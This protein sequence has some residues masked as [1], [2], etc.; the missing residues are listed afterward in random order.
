[1]KQES[2]RKKISEIYN[3]YQDEIETACPRWAE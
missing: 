2:G 3:E 1:M